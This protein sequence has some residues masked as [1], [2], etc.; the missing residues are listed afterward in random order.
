MI[1]RVI[2][3]ITLAVLLGIGLVAGAQAQ[4]LAM[5]GYVDEFVVHVKGSCANY[6]SLVKKLVDANRAN[7]GDN[8]L[9]LEST[10]GEGNVYRFVAT[11]M[12]YGDIETAQGKFMAALS[13]GLGGEMGAMKLL[14][15]LGSCAESTQGILRARRWDLSLGKPADMAAYAKVIGSTR[16]IRL[17]TVHVR[18]G[19]AG[20]YE[21]AVKSA[22]AAM[23]KANPDAQSWFTQSVAGDNGTTY[24]ISQ[25]RPSLA[26]FDSGMSM[27][28]MMGDTAFDS[29]QKEIS[30]V[31]TRTDVAIYQVSGSLSNEPDD[32]V[33]VAPNFWR[34]KPPAPPKAPA[35]KAPAKKN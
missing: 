17:Y 34:P 28:Q 4:G 1:R 14:G 22:N 9:A 2:C 13:K 30:E 8:W 33:A 12:T 25:L 35:T 18:P 21:A 15:E 19:M 24:Y 5:D 31:V 29:Y 10:Y 26:S 20:R 7:G 11:R 23:L 6:D 3:S 32:V 27:R 16:W